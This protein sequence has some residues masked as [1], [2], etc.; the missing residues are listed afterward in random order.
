MQLLYIFLA[1]TAAAGSPKRPHVLFVVADDYGWNDVG[2]HTNQSAAGYLNTANPDGHPVSSK[3]AG[4]M[5]TPTIDQLASEGIKLES[6]YVQPLC[7]PTRATIM[8]GRYV[9]H[10]GIG[11]S[12][13]VSSGGEPYVLCEFSTTIPAFE[14]PNRPRFFAS[15]ALLL[16]RATLL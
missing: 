1:P 8:T 9:Q 5:R 2:Y 4:V 14:A 15:V 13:I 11:P 10:H 12:V 3:T 6:Y 16:D 7:S